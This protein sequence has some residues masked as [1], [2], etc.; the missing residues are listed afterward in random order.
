MYPR[1]YLGALGT[2]G[3]A[4]VAL[5][6]GLAVYGLVA[7]AAGTL[8]PLLF[9]PQPAWNP[10]DWNLSALRA[11]ATGI[12]PPNG[13]YWPVVWR[14]ISYVGVAI[15]GCVAIGYPVAYFTALHARRT[16]PLILALL[17]LPLIVSYMLRMLAWVGLLAPDG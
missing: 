5:F 15:I 1:R 8:D 16:K 9:Q 7:T 17:V 10:L 12:L 14:T 13:A 3:V 4:W 2:P 11:A 6:V